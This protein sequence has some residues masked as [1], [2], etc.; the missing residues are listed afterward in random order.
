MEFGRLMCGTCLRVHSFLKLN[1]DFSQSGNMLS[2][3]GSADLGLIEAI[4]QLELCNYRIG[5]VEVL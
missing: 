1:C 4:Q 2:L 3:I 5:T